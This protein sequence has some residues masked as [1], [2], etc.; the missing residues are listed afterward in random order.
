MSRCF[1][2]PKASFV[3]NPITNI[4]MFSLPISDQ[5]TQ[6]LK[7]VAG[8]GIH[9][10][11]HLHLQS[12][13]DHFGQRYES[14]LENPLADD[15][16]TEGLSSQTDDW[17]LRRQEAAR[18]AEEGFRMSAFGS[19]PQI[20]QHP[21]GELCDELVGMF[22]V[23]E[24]LR[25]LLEDMYEVTSAR[26]LEEE[27]WEAIMGVSVEEGTDID[28]ESDA[29]SKTRVGLRQLIKNMKAKVQK[30]G[31]AKW[32]ERWAAKIFVIGVNYVQGWI[33]LQALRRE[34]RK[35]DLDMP[36]FPLF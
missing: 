17:N 23:V 16:D 25:G 8:M 30:R 20:C 3:F 15:F 22:G 34:A 21:E 10:L 5:R 28:A 13:R 2:I 4:I 29:S 31:P 18:M 6:A 7:Q 11:F 33:V 36:K 9:R 24:A 26:G 27:D 19:I 32:Y 35:R 1:N 14:M 12:L